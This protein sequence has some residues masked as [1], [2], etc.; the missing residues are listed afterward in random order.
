MRKNL[1]TCW[2][3]LDLLVAVAAIGYNTIFVPI[4][5]TAIIMGMLLVQ[6]VGEPSNLFRLLLN[7][8]SCIGE[9]LGAVTL[10]AAALMSTQQADILSHCYDNVSLPGW[11]VILG[12]GDL[13]ANNR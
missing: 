6:G 7:I 4:L 1:H 10:M 8:L 11:Q 9:M 5:L 13:C 2:K 12:E 3:I